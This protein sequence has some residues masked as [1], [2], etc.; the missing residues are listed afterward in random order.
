[1]RVRLVLAAAALLALPAC[2]DP[3]VGT[4]CAKGYSPCGSKCVLAGSC[5]LR[6]AGEGADVQT[7]TLPDGSL[8]EAESNADAEAVE[9]GP[10]AD[11]N[12][13]TDGDEHEVGDKQTDV[14]PTA[15]V[16]FGDAGGGQADGPVPPVA[17]DGPEG[18]SSGDAGASNAGFDGSGPTTEVDRAPGAADAGV[19]SDLGGHDATTTDVSAGDSWLSCV[20]CTDV[21][22]G[23]S[24]ETSAR[25]EDGGAADDAGSGEAGTTDAS[26]T[27]ADTAWGDAGPLHCAEPLVA[28]GD[29]CVDLTTDPENCGTC[30]AICSSSVCISGACLV[31]ASEETVCGQECINTASDPDNCGGCGVPCASGLCSNNHCE[32]NG[33]GRIIVIGHDYLKN[34]P[35]MNRILGNAVFLWPVNPVSLLTYKGAAN[36]TA[37]AGANGAIAQVATATGRQVQQTDVAAADVATQLAGADVFLIYGQEQARDAT[38]NQLGQ[39]WASAMTTFVKRGGTMILLDGFYSANAGTVQVISQAGL[40]SIQRNVSE[41]NSVCTVIARGDALASGLPRTYRCEQNSVNFTTTEVGPAVTSVVESG[42]SVV[43]DKVF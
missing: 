6:D 11:G 20:G 18:A 41:T 8:G 4:Q 17:S 35:A 12:L 14:A 25:F 9:T 43:I 39:D 10:A 36:P 3:I 22:D 34:R 27:L 16:G 1:M 40:F 24:N 31:C 37:I 23:S 30:N 15:E 13:V 21:G 28:C 5:I 33:T 7:A 32:A 19:G 42:T 2:L 26:G 29:Q 38:L